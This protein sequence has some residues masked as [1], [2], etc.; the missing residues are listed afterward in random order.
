MIFVDRKRVSPSKKWAAL[1]RSELARAREFYL[2]GRKARAQRRHDFN[3]RLWFE[4]RGSL[5]ELFYNKCA[6][7]ES[8]LV[9]VKGDVEHFRPKAEATG[10]R[11]SL[12]TRSTTKRATESDPDAYWWLAWDWDNLLIACAVC[13]SNKRNRFPTI[14]SRA[15]A[16]ARGAELAAE[17]AILLNPCEDRPDQ[18]LVFDEKGVVSSRVPPEQSALNMPKDVD[19]GAITIEILGLNRPDLVEARRE[20]LE[21]LLLM[22]RSWLRQKR[23][24][25]ASLGQ[26]VGQVMDDAAP[27][28]AIQ[29]QFLVS[30]LEEHLAKL[31][32]KERTELL[33]MLQVYGLLTMFALS[34]AAEAPPSAAKAGAKHPRRAATVDSDP[35]ASIRIVDFRAIHDLTLQ[36][37]GEGS[38]ADWKLLL[39][40]NGTGKSSALQAI[41]LALMGPQYVSRFLREFRLKPVNLLRRV[42][43]E[44]LAQRA[45][46]RVEFRSGALI[47]M[48][49]DADGVRFSKPPPARLFLRAFG[50]TRL[51]PRRNVRRPSGDP[52]V[53]KRVTNLFDPARPVMNAN[54]WLVRLKG[55]HFASAALSIKDL[56]GLPKDTDL[57]VKSGQV[58][59]P[60][61]GTLHP[62][63]ELSAGYESVLSTV[64]EVVGGVLGSVH[65]LRHATG[66]VLLD[67]IDAHLHPRWK[68]RIVES[69]RR[70]FPGMQFIVT[71]HEPLCLRGA[72]DKEVVLFRRDDDGAV[73]YISDLPSPK[74]LR[75]D[76]LL[77]SELFG[78]YTAIDPALDDVF[79]DYYRLLAR[80]DSLDAAERAQLVDLKQRLPAAGIV[81][82]LGDTRREQLVYEAVDQYLAKT[83]VHRNPD[84]ANAM[85]AEMR[86]ARD[87]VKRRIA[88]IW[89]TDWPVA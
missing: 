11:F 70:T 63:D 12:R 74:E 32:Q 23:A 15:K 71:T 73:A 60:L 19:R 77:T 36:F 87:D 45:T 82:M 14:G 31:S 65:D 50:S 28:A 29:R 9:A 5:K 46:V 72:E 86:G 84:Q 6:Y 69:L 56:L 24:N 10:A 85:R 88:K 89:T 78:L 40:E 47:R 4:A 59:L 25:L 61:H 38:R 37:P 3:N 83:L 39:G 55:D 67:E 43:D 30:S 53:H 49:I 8:P 26:I 20:R 34:R 80:G 68:M 54:A 81:S 44:K 62:L 58:K 79:Q 2:I 35:I 66:I 22:W 48:T 52:H 27:Y 75:V 1:A 16:E 42:R 17:K 7:C 51:L 13:N 76:Q 33:S 18:Y 41:S 57:G 64:C 21:T